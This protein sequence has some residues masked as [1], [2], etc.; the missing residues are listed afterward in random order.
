[1]LIRASVVG[2][3]IV[4]WFLVAAAP[5]AAAHQDGCLITEHTTPFK[6]HM[7]CSSSP[8]T[9]FGNVQGPMVRVHLLCEEPA[10]NPCTA[11]VMVAGNWVKSCDE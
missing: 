9:C 4:A 1:M 6:V 7:A 8:N 10:T 11:K 3:A 5:P 2:I